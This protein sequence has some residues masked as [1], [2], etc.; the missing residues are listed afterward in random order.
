MLFL[1][2][3]FQN[4]ACKWISDSPSHVEFSFLTSFS[5][6]IYKQV[7][8]QP[9]ISFQKKNFKNFLFFFFLAEKANYWYVIEW[10]GNLTYLHR[11]PGCLSQKN[12]LSAGSYPL[13]SENSAKSKNKAIKFWSMCV[14]EC[15]GW[16]RDNSCTFI[17]ICVCFKEQQLSSNISKI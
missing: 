13:N 16:E 9:E 1:E 15:R 14:C 6:C 2:R 3:Y 4:P 7:N 11:I 5:V 8:W 17:L 10:T 12:L